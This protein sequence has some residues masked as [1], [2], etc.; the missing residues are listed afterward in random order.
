[1]KD[2]KFSYEDFG[3]GLAL[4]LVTGSLIA[5]IFAPQS[6]EDT[7][8]QIANKATDLKDS[9]ED[10][11]EQAKKSIEETGAK[12]EGVIGRRDKS[13]RKKIEELREELEKYKLG[14]A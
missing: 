4:G 1:M 11:I 3:L 10:L 8:R 13:V 2:T 5:L 9:A 14:E 7:R 12:I 6:G